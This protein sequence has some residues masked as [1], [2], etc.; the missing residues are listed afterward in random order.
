[1][2]APKSVAIIELGKGH[3]ELIPS[4]LRMLHGHADQIFYVGL[5]RHL[6]ILDITKFDRALTIHGKS[7]I[8]GLIELWH[9]RQFLKGNKVTH[10]IFN[11]TKGSK[12]LKLTYL[13]PSSIHQSGVL[14]ELLDLQR[15]T[16]Q[17]L[18]SRRLSKYMVLSQSIFVHATK[19]KTKVG[20]Y[21]Y[22]IYFTTYTPK[23][24]DQ[25][26]ISIAIPGNIEQKRRD[27]LGLIDQ[28]R[29]KALKNIQFIVLG[30][31]TFRDGP[32]IKDK[33]QEA[34]LTDHFKFF[35][36]FI[37]EDTYY[38]LVSNCHAVAPLLHPN[39]KDYEKYMTS[40]ISGSFN[41]A[42]GFKKPLL[43]PHSLANL[44]EFISVSIGYD[45]G[46]L[47][48]FLS[49]LDPAALTAIASAITDDSRF[50]LKNQRTRYLSIFNVD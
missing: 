26:S 8:S 23:S 10:V 34:G 43:L 2:K 32:M 11:T 12:I 40:K 1:M 33:V 22:P 24:Q 49:D 21:F 17:K 28:L 7:G 36:G 41:L 42:F 50:D 35:E 47:S 31:S 38:R 5:H 46:S 13:I 9:I 14:H 19:Q 25:I 30:D 20:N 48:S 27:Y 45:M 15:S 4:H 16:S 44:D 37:D 6:K 3:T 39:V 18:I 29:G